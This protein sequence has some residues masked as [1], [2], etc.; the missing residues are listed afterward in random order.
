M[1]IWKDCPIELFDQY[2]ELRAVKPAEYTCNGCVFVEVWVASCFWAYPEDA[3]I[4][5][6]PIYWVCKQVKKICGDRPACVIFLSKDGDMDPVRWGAA[7]WLL[8]N[9][10]KKENVLQYS[11]LYTQSAPENVRKMCDTNAWRR[12]KDVE[13]FRK[14]LDTLDVI[15]YGQANFKSGSGQI[16]CKHPAMPAP[17][18]AFVQFVEGK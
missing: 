16:R 15:V 12:E 2:I 3:Q 14:L 1:S 4:M 11:V 6:R 9:Q 7:L 18:E 8:L 13:Q 17:L 5:R 10:L